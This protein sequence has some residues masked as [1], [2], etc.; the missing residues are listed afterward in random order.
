MDSIIITRLLIALVL[1][2]IIGLERGWT[3]RESPEELGGDGLRNFG[4]V[5]LFGGIAALLA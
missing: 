1:G 2:L 4:L 5:G 3:S